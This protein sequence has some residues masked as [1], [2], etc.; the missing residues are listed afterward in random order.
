MKLCGLGVSGKPVYEVNPIV[1]SADLRQPGP[2]IA[3][4]D[5]GVVGILPLQRLIGNE[6]GERNA[7]EL[8]LLVSQL[9]E[10]GDINLHRIRDQLE[11]AFLDFRMPIEEAGLIDEVLDHEVILAIGVGQDFGN[12]LE[13]RKRRTDHMEQHEIEFTGPAQVEKPDVGEGFERVQQRP[14][15]DIDDANLDLAGSRALSSDRPPW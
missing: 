11:I 3:A 9:V 7:P 5:E 2:H 14:G 12:L 1:L 13:G 15:T 10:L 4:Q 8:G 6:S